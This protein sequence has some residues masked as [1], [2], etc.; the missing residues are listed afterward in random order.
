MST[1]APCC[2]DCMAGSGL[3]QIILRS[4][5]TSPAVLQLVQAANAGSSPN[6]SEDAR[7]QAIAV[8]E[9]AKAGSPDICV[10]AFF[11]L[12]QSSGDTGAQLNGLTLL[13]H[14]LRNR[15]E[16]LSPEQQRELEQY[17]TSVVL[18]PETSKQA[19]PIR[20]QLAYAISDV[21]V[22]LGDQSTDSIL[23]NTIPQLVQQS[24][25]AAAIGCRITQFLSEEVAEVPLGKRRG[26]GAFGSSDVASKRRRS[27][28]ALMTAQ[29]QQ[30]LT[31]MV[32]AASVYMQAGLQAM[33]E[34]QA[35]AA[36][37]AQGAVQAALEALAALAGW[38]PLK[39]VKESQVLD[40]CASLI[41]T[42]ALQLPAVEVVL[43]VAS[44][45]SKQSSKEK[46]DYR[47]LYVRVAQFLVSA[48]PL[49]LPPDAPL[50][51]VLEQEDAAD[52]ACRLCD[53]LVD[54]VLA[55]H[56][57]ILP[58]DLQLQALMRLAAYMGSEFLP[59]AARTFPAWRRLVQGHERAVHK[60]KG[61]APSTAIELPPECLQ[62]LLRHCLKTL[63]VVMPAPDQEDA[64]PDYS[65]GLA[66]WKEACST[67]KSAV[68]YILSEVAAILTAGALAEIRGL[69]DT[70]EGML[71]AAASG[72]G[73]RPIPAAAHA[74]DVLAFVLDAII[75]P[76][77]S[78]ASAVE[79][80]GELTALAHQVM[81]YQA[82]HFTLVPR[83]AKA[84]EAL[85]P[86]LVLLPD[87][88]PAVIE[89]FFAL[90]DRMHD[91]RGAAV[92][93]SDSGPYMKE[94]R[95]TSKCYYTLATKA[96][97]AFVPFLEAIAQ[98][99]NAL[100]GSG[101]LG[102][103]DQ[104][105]ISEGLLASAAS[106]GADL[107][108]RVVAALVSPVRPAWEGLLAKV[109]GSA[110]FA[111]NMLA[112]VGR[113]GDGSVHVG[114]T[115][116]RAFMYYSLQLLLYCARQAK[117]VTQKQGF[118]ALSAHI[119][120]MLPPA[121]QLHRC[122]QGLA[123][124]AV[125]AGPLAEMASVLDISPLERASAVSQHVFLEAK[126]RAPELE[127]SR[128]DPTSLHAVRGWIRQCKELALMLIMECARGVPQFWTSERL[129]AMLPRGLLD[130]LDL[131]E[132][133]SIRLT[134]HHGLLPLVRSCPPESAEAW[135]AA[136]FAQF[137][138]VVGTRLHGAWPGLVARVK[139]EVGEAK[140]KQTEEE[141]VQEVLLREL[142]RDVLEVL[143]AF[144]GSTSFPTI[145][146]DQL[147]ALDAAS[148]LLGAMHRVRAMSARTLDE[149]SMEA[150]AADK[151][152]SVSL[153]SIP[154]DRTVAHALTPNHSGT[155]TAAVQLAAAAMQW[156]DMQTQI[157]A[158]AVC[159]TV[160]AA[161]GAPLNPVAT[162][163]GVCTGGALLPPLLVPCLLQQA[164][165]ALASADGPHVA[166][167]LL[168]LIRSI[169]VARETLQP[170]AAAQIQQLL[171]NVTA[172]AI[173]QLDQD[174]ETNKTEKH[175][176]DT[177]KRFFVAAGF[178]NLD[179]PSDI[180]KKQIRQARTVEGQA[181]GGA[182]EE[183][184][185]PDLYDVVIDPS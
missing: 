18:R 69:V 185:W 106:G 136:A 157:R 181:Q 140:A 145:P 29:G 30:L 83:V 165:R 112:P 101:A 99:T 160:A 39:V 71:S 48:V 1:G 38:L 91:L 90:I 117:A 45:S 150:P 164:V 31:L 125:L 127:A 105:T 62:L 50:E 51:Q 3:L 138:Q 137:L 119:E 118:E 47:D 32:Q 159:R 172:A 42:P 70:V 161:A 134:V 80:Q 64:F 146:T 94:Q 35:A 85:G 78:Y 84:L 166:S 26:S 86:V 89:A 52:G 95:A 25:S 108:A 168:L 24:A 46:E 57:Q 171:P 173:A 9:Q 56:L 121:V 169:Y 162:A 33:A 154:W 8:V 177:F 180:Q 179:E 111:G 104:N 22:Q 120:W 96:P 14:V 142:S 126:T 124:P 73:D 178:S 36:A 123:Q 13:R 37:D 7:K 107:F 133:R 11:H 81:R 116:R 122:L 176:K 115:E 167:E 100:V 43:Q 67:C 97:R 44:R 4:F 135:L 49:M 129:R 98:R 184:Q 93:S 170:S 109:P 88:T 151:A 16:A 183:I 174:L 55:G 82:S 148:P 75:A 34:G 163:C 6:L 66:E 15:W 79:V 60:P 92:E 61:S 23:K 144:A 149:G 103:A 131:Q 156:P 19:S 74:L 87:L 76:V 54:L 139:G 113:G 128:M 72:A 143:R 155:V 12:F 59:L 175:H 21:A 58:R 102:Y 53:A 77:C 114:G 17:I 130:S 5:M 152:P 40:A 110:E 28:L 158:V 132:P 41:Q 147:Q 2:V 141:M 63:H 68:K 27:L 182:S 10:Q 20:M 153:N 65:H